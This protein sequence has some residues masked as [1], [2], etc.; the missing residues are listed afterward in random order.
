MDAGAEWQN[1]A[2]DI[3]R[4]FPVNGKFSAAQK[5]VYEV[6]L[7]TN[8][9]VINA[10]KAGVAYETLHKL[11][12]K[13][14]TQGLIDLK[15]L[16]G[17]L[18]ILL[19][20]K[21]FRRFYMHGIGHFLGLDVHD[22]GARHSLRENMCL[23]VEPGLYIPDEPDIPAEFRGVGIRIEDNVIVGIDACEVYTQDA[24]KE[25]DEIENLMA[26]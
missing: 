9:A 1:Y 18:D 10:V 20:K 16:S 5:A 22:V 8:K 6:V 23:T 25:I 3:S 11:S 7:A 14:L 21:A 4:T 13:M 12:E 17:S 15:L 2:G 24:P 19:K 26:G